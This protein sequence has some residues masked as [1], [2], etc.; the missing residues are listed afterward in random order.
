VVSILNHHYFGTLTI[1]KVPI[2]ELPEQIGA[3]PS[4]GVLKQ[5]LHRNEDSLPPL[6]L[7]VSL[8]K[9]QGSAP[10]SSAIPVL[11]EGQMS[12]VPVN[13]GTGL[14]LQCDRQNARSGQRKACKAIIYANCWFNNATGLDVVL[15]RGTEPAAIYNNLSVM[16]DEAWANVDSEDDPSGFHV[17]LLGTQRRIRLPFVGVGQSAKLS[18][19]STHDCILKSDF[20]SS[21]SSHGVSS[22]LFSLIPA[23]L[24]FNTLDDLEIGFRQDGQRAKD[25]WI[26][27]KTGCSAIYWSFE[28]CRRLQLAVRA[29]GSVGGGS[30]NRREGQWSA[31]F[32]VSE[33]GIG[34][35]PIRLPDAS[36][37]DHLFCVQIQQCSSQL[38]TLTVAGQDAC[39]QLVNRHPCLVVDGCFANESID[40]CHFV[41]VHGSKIPFGSSGTLQLNSKRR[42][43]LLLGDV[44]SHKST[45]IELALDTPVNRIVEFEFPISVRLDIVQRVAHITISP[46]GLLVGGLSKGNS[47]SWKLEANVRIPALNIGIRGGQTESAESFCCQLRGLNLQCLQTETRETICEL[48]GLQV[49]H[50]RGRSSKTKEQRSVILASLPQPQPWRLKIVREQLS[51]TDAILRSMSLEFFPAKDNEGRPWGHVLVFRLCLLT[52]EKSPENGYKKKN[53]LSWY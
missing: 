16:D 1:K 15:V 34:C 24:A 27:P 31:A 12:P 50:V 6:L 2:Y 29:S 44:A 35:F 30:R 45:S 8:A 49:D 32:E 40:G 23:L 10:W 25:S 7:S 36:S 17:V 28:G 41:A 13:L 43:C 9:Q 47:L 19:S 14:T 46:V 4:G 3:A 42:V 22:T 48:G 11:V 37:K 51:E 18:L 33:H 21:S 38:I 53:T 5:P 20:I 39:H 26:E 52:Y